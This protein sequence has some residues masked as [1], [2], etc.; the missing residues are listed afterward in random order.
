MKAK[1]P[2]KPQTAKVKDAVSTNKTLPP[3]KKVIEITED[4]KFEIETL[5]Q[6]Q[7]DVAEF[8]NNYTAEFERLM[9]LLNKHSQASPFN[10]TADGKR[11]VVFKE[12]QKARIPVPPFQSKGDNYNIKQFIKLFTGREREVKRRLAKTNEE[13]RERI[14]FINGGSV[15]TTTGRDPDGST[16]TKTI[17]APSSAEAIERRFYRYSF[18]QPGIFSGLSGEDMIG[19]ME[20]T[21]TIAEKSFTIPIS[22][23]A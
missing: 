17:R 1:V 10:I 16:F 5:R 11:R 8:A 21:Y 15:T 9:H 14:D 23:E 18:D 2:A 20:E 3:K 19:R 7:D 12:N 13:I 22:E 4:D 6:I